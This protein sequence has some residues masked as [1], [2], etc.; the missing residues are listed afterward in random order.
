[1]SR[2]MICVVKN[3]NVFHLLECC[4]FVVCTTLILFAYSKERTLQGKT[5]FILTA[6]HFHCHS[7]VLN[8]N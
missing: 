8:G 4:L 7:L 6:A 5:S 3:E 2:N 1:M